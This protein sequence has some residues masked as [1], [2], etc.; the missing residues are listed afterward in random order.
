WQ[1]WIDGDAISAPVAAGDEVVVATF[2]GTVFRFKQESG[3]L[4]SAIRARATSAPVVLGDKMHFS[5]RAESSGDAQ[6]GLCMWE[7]SGA[8]YGNRFAAKAARYLDAGVQDKADLKMQGA[9]LDA[10]NG[11]A[12]GAPSSAN[13]QQAAA[14]VGQASVATL[15]SFQGSRV[16]RYG[17]RN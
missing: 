1:R 2:T 17:N 9:K 12:A 13:A 6:E 4:L 15:Q 7:N 5:Q 16:L 8:R 14:N 10:G 3:E 11:F